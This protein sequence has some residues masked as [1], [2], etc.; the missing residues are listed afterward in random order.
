MKCLR[1]NT[2]A[3][4]MLAVKMRN[5]FLKCT[6]PLEKYLPTLVA[7]AEMFSHFEINSLLKVG[8][9]R[10]NCFFLLACTTTTNPSDIHIYQQMHQLLLGQVPILSL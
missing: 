1:A 7:A 8:K 5:L 3:R 4:N 10:V 6:I 9:G 2:T